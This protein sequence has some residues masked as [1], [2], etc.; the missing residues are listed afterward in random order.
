[1]SGPS[2][3]RRWLLWALI[4]S[5]GVNLAVLGLVAGAVFH[6]PPDRPPREGGW[7]IAHDL[8]D[9]FR[10]EMLREL[11]RDRG[12]WIGQ[13]RQLHEQKEALAAALESEPFEVERIESILGEGRATLNALAERSAAILVEQVS[14]MD[15][16]DRAA[17]AERLRGPHDHGPRRKHRDR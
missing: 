1:M 15:A 17:Y 8:P 14:R 3:K 5:L 12:K 9:P 11:R 7:A 13:R 10:E 4:G 16:E 6:G 2:R